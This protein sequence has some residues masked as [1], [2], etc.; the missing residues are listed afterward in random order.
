MCL[1]GIKEGAKRVWGIK[2]IGIGVG[3]IIKSDCWHSRKLIKNPWLE[4]TFK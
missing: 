4:S 2:Q 1:I 3:L